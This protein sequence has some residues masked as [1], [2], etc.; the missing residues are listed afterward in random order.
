MDKETIQQIAAEVVAQL[1]LGDRYWMYMYLAIN[2]A[3]AAAL[4][5]R[6]Q[7]DFDELLRQLRINTDAVESIK[8][9]IGQRDWASV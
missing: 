2:V 4:E 7:R 8:S 5:L 1:P 3:V 6:H 9:E